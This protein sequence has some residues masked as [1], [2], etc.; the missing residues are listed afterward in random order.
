M[1]AAF[2]PLF[3]QMGLKLSN[4]AMLI[5]LPCGLGNCLPWGGP[6]ARAAAVL[7]LEVNDLFVAMLPVLGASFI[8]VFFMAYI[9][10]KNERKRLGLVYGTG[11]ALCKPHRRLAVFVN[12]PN[13]NE[14]WRISERIL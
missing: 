10:G 4:L 5:I 6:L 13:R 2:V 14:F 1:T 11:A 12:G 8:Y 3:K 7:N 9:M